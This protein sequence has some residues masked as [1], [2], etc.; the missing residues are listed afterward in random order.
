MKSVV[1]GFREKYI[2]VPLITVPMKSPLYPL[3]VDVGLLL[4]V[5]NMASRFEAED[6]EE[7]IVHFPF[8]QET[9]IPVPAD[10]EAVEIVVI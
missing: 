3:R 10:M 9:T 1:L 5:P 4:E 2:V 7:V 6:P 8:V